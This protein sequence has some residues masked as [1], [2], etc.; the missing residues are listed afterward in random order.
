[1]LSTNI[2]AIRG[3]R[4]FG[5][6]I[7][8]KDKTFAIKFDTGA[9]ETI[10]SIEKVLGKV[11][12]KQRE[13]IKEFIYS[14]N[15]TPTSFNTASGDSFI[16]FPTCLKNVFIGQCKFD[17]FYYYLVIDK[18]KANKQIAL[19][20]DN[21]IDCCDFSHKAHSDIIITDFD[22]SM[23]NVSPNCLSTDEILEVVST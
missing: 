5:I 8:Y 7:I 11:T 6:P 1:M 16:G 4:L 2:I 17:V 12:D 22:F 9:N 23:Y 19:L 21:F 20:G 18:M 13:K 15:V 10:I 14:K 3:N